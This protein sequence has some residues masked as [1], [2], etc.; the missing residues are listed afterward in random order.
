MNYKLIEGKTERLV[1]LCKQVQRVHIRA[2]GETYINDELFRR[3]GIRLRYIDYSEYQ[4]T[5][6]C[7]LRLNTA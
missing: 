7:F 5:S 3:E 2:S 6:N 1:D 4:N